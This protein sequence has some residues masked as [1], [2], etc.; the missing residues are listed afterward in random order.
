M[1]KTIFTIEGVP[2]AFK[3]YTSGR[4]WN[5]WATPYFEMSEALAVM[6]AYNKYSGGAMIY[7]KATDAFYIFPTKY[8]DEALFEGT[9][10]NTDD[11]IKHLYGI[12]AYYFI[13]DAVNDDDV[14]YLAEEIEEFI[15]YHDTYQYHDEYGIE[16]EQTINSIVE[17][18]KN[19]DVLCKAMRIMKNEELEADE[20]FEA[21]GG[22]L[23]V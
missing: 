14:K 10:Y 5:G 1:Y 23:N 3:G 18:F 19:L 2:T 12:G 8:T 7:D 11:G 21:L 15:F 4:L 17:E 9:N 13:W 22:I 16:R 20:R 6:A